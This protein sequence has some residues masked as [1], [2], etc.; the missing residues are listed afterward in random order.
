VNCFRYPATEKKI[1][2]VKMILIYA[3][4]IVVICFVAGTVLKNPFLCTIKGTVQTFV[5]KCVTRLIRSAVKNWRSGN[6]L[7]SFLMKQSH[8]RSIKPFPAAYGFLR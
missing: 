6:F 2:L 5:L 8:E 4:P 7:K 3:K 1:K